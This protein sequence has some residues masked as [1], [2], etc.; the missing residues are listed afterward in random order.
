MLLVGQQKFALG[1]LLNMKKYFWLLALAF[2][3]CGEDYE[4]PRE[5][6]APAFIG[7]APSEV[8]TIIIQKFEAGSSFTRP[9]DTTLVGY[10]HGQ[11]VRIGDT[12]MVYRP[13]E[14]DNRE[15]DLRFINFFDNRTVSITEIR[16]DMREGHGGGLFGLDRMECSSPIVSY[17]RDNV[18]VVPTGV[19]SNV[20]YIRR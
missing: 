16:Y 14:V 10:G 4:C 11:F 8:D 6:L 9:I 5:R 13:F 2:T 12:T 18:Q 20:V 17:K 7:Y 3:S 15:Y 19:Y 1:G